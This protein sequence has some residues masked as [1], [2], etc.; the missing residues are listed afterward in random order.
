MEFTEHDIY[1]IGK[2]HPDRAVQFAPFAALSGFYDRVKDAE[3]VPGPRHELQDY[4]IE[5]IS[6]VL[7]TLNRGDLIELSFFERHGYRCLQAVVQ[8]VIIP[9]KMLRMRNSYIDF[10]DIGSIRLIK[11]AE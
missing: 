11:R 8:E 4:E 1:S 5:E 10:E 9:Y 3:F 7:S 2:P 6:C